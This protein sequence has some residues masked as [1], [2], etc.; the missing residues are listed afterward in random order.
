[1]PGM[2][3][4][5]I[6]FFWIRTGSWHLSSHRIMNARKQE[7]IRAILDGWKICLMMK[8][9]IFTLAETGNSCL[10]RTSAVQSLK[11]ATSVKKVFINAATAKIAPTKKSV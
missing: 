10:L 6:M 4:K 3:V 8:Q 1:M 2:K 7:N 9:V 5:R 11:P